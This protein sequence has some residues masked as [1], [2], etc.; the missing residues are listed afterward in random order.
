MQF[1]PMKRRTFITLVGGAAAWPLAA[2]AQQAMPVIG[3]LSARSSGESAAHIAVFRRSLSEIG[4]VESQNVLIE[5]RWADGHYNQLPTLAS[6]L[7]A[8]KVN[9]LVAVA[10][11]SPHAAKA[12]TPTI[13]IVFAANGDPVRDGLVPSLNRPGGNMTGITIFGP[14]AATKRLQFLHELVPQAAAIAYMMNPNNPRG[15]VET[16]AVQSAARSLG[17]E[18]HV[19][20]AGSGAELD[21]VFAS[22]VQQG[23]PLLVASDP[24]FL[25]RRDQLVSLTARHRTPAIYYLREFAEAGGLMTYGNK[26]TDLYR[27]VGI[28]VG[29]ILKGE[30]PADLPVHQS[31]KFELVINLKAAKALGLNIP[32]A[33][34][35]AAD[36]VIE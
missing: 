34:Q 21:T 32:L 7:V 31:T 2:W 4:Y 30:K 25:T 1:T 23:H 16:E 19:L 12:A 24:F 5:Y 8:R 6:E 18:L 27:L 29:R 15:S 3:F 36:E 28:Y 9:V 35:V 22:T 20:R 14:D 13:P 33:L 11:P 26:L 10:D 17:K